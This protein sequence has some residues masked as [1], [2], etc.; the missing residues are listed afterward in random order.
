VGDSY[1]EADT[2]RMYV[3]PK[4]KAAGWEDEMIREQMNITAGKIIPE[5][6][7]GKRLAPKK[8]D[9]TLFYAPNFK[10]AV[11]EA[12]SIYS[13][14]GQGMQ[15]AIEYA[16]MLEIKFAYSTN[17][18]GI[19]EYDFISKKQSTVDRF[20]SPIELWHRLNTHLN[21]DEKQKE[22]LLHPFNRESRSPDGKVIEPRY[23]QEIAVNAAITA[24]LHGKKR[25]LLTLATGTGKTFIAFQIAR[26][27]WETQSPHPKILFLVDRDVLITQAMDGNFSPFGQARHR[28]QRKVQKAYEM[29]FA[30][31]QALD[32]DKE[33]S[34]LYKEYP[35]D[36]FDYVI[37]DECHRGTANEQS[38]WR[39]ILNHFSTAVHVGM[40]ATP[41]RDADSLD[42]YDYFGVPLYTYSLRQ[43]IED[44][45][46]APY[47]I[48]R[49]ILDIDRE[50]YT[51][52]HG[53]RDNEG[54]LLEQRKY[55]ISDFD[56]ILTVEER[57]K[58]VA[59]HLTQ[60]LEK[61]NQKFNKTILFCQNSEHAE[62][63]T[64]LLRNYSGEGPDYCVRIVS[65]EGEIARYYLDKFTNPKEDFPVIAA[66]SR[67][68]STGVDAPTCKVIALDK[69]I[70]SMTEFKQIIGRGTR[71]F[72]PREKLWFTIIDYRG[73]SRLFEDA[74][75]D[76]PAEGITEE[77]LTKLTDEKEQR[78]L[79]MAKKRQE[80]QSVEPPVETKTEELR[81]TYVIQG[82]KVEIIAQSVKIFDQSMGGHRLVSYEEYT[83][84]TVRRLVN[85]FQ[86][87]L[88]KI[89]VEP[90]KRT[91]FIKELERRGITFEHLL[92]ITEN[93]SSDPFDILLHITYNSKLK[94]RFQRAESVKKEKIFLEK[95]PEKAKQ[96]L[97]V[98][99][100]H[101]AEE[102]Y[103]ELEGRNILRLEKFEKFG[104]D[105]VIIKDIFKGTD[106]Y[107]KAINEMVKAIYSE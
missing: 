72:E 33:E 62:G 61:N 88:N 13:T 49:P 73:A 48:V 77:E 98:I 1:S 84:E 92:E 103:R 64:K 6:R 83:G 40:T 79:E 68:M 82:V 23:Y 32:V 21:V 26:K 93:Y 58:R 3:L 80:E 51:P 100:E 94:T 75:W 55:T 69:V 34:E 4:L 95:Y 24:I 67:L 50:G 18:K 105:Y 59:S 65:A 20:S 2:C 60:F 25:I 15:Q 28:I 10:I 45:F 106:N 41:K 35:A 30:L 42:T 27:L 90:E 97:E 36:F 91:H 11:V 57:R 39:E 99:L 96:V 81:E 76:G 104:G 29:Y 43:G 71:V 37:I 70:N 56:R 86:M 107:D 66:T 102:G 89:W 8:P 17:G 52:K 46:L 53:E 31:Y 85:D 63:M 14:P 38:N 12:K 44:G 22:A 7:G 9:Y 5:G 19:E 78:L 47:F 87:D 101:Y 16:K 74:D 54:K